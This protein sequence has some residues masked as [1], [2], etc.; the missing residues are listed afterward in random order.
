M[1]LFYPISKYSYFSICYTPLN[2]YYFT[3][4]SY[5]FAHLTSFRR[6]TK[7][8]IVYGSSVIQLPSAS[9]EAV[10]SPIRDVSRVIYIRFSIY[11]GQTEYD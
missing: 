3:H 7:F 1:S 11:I 4:Q 10:R 8:T 5:S 2:C 9:I 6:I